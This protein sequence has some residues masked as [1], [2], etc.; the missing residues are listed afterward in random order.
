MKITNDVYLVGS[1]EFG[2]SNE[3]DCHAYLI[4]GGKEAALIDCGVGYDTAKIIQNV[5]E[6]IDIKKL[7]RVYLTHLHADHCGGSRDLQK[8]GIQIVAPAREWRDMQENPKE[9]IEAFKISQNTGCYPE[10]KDFIFPEPDKFLYDKDEFKVG[11]YRLKAIEVRGHSTGMLLY[12]LK[13]KNRNILFSGDYIFANGVVGLLNCP[14]CDLS[15]YREDIKKLQNLNI[16]M[17]LPGHHMIVFNHGQDHI[18]KAIYNM[19]RAFM[20]PSF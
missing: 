6:L 17:L 11:T 4:D 10:D 5:S 1:G 3:Y 20:P 19:S 13:T 8:L 7:K 18:D 12:L 9:I 2:V 16:D 15:L 14:G